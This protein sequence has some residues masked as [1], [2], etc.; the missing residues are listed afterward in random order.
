MTAFDSSIPA[1]ITITL[2]ILTL[3]FTPYFLLSFRYFCG[4]SA[5]RM[6]RSIRAEIRHDNLVALVP[7]MLKS[8]PNSRRASR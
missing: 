3:P 6:R 8:R 2:L 1:S 4:G 5:E 7:V